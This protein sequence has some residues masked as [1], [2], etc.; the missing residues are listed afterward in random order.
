MWV[1]FGG[2]RS[3]LSTGWGV[4]RTGG[5]TAVSAHWE[6][7]CPSSF[8]GVALVF[9]SNLSS[10]ARGPSFTLI[11]EVLYPWRV[12]TEMQWDCKMIKG[13]LENQ[14]VN[15]KGDFKVSRRHILR[16]KNVNW[17]LISCFYLTQSVH[18]ILP[19]NR[20]ITDRARKATDGP[21][22]TRELSPW[23]EDGDVCSC[24]RPEKQQGQP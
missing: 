8:V 16:S 24:G 12:W 15:H 7:L 14:N 4:G 17:V 11:R 3:T 6:T 20:E 10:S 9:L 1:A 18:I 2:G 21:V 13:F 23:W 5:D 22:S 19:P